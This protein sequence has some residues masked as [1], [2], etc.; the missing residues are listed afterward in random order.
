M[1]SEGK[2]MV[3]V[4]S[5][6]NEWLP[7]VHE[8]IPKCAVELEESFNIA[9]N[10]LRSMNEIIETIERR[11]YANQL[12]GVSNDVVE[13]LEQAMDVINDILEEDS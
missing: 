2:R 13:G 4:E 6:L 10:S 7:I 9:I 12:A 1:E 8:G 11:I 5:A 3:T